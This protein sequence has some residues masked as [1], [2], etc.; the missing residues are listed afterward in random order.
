MKISFARRTQ[1][2]DA[3]FDA[4]P[5]DQYPAEPV[6]Q[7]SAQP[8]EQFSAA[9]AEQYTAEPAVDG[10]AIDEEIPDASV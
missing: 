8:A 4:E 6:E 2:V 5:M 7:F 10:D 9:P 1:P 3:P